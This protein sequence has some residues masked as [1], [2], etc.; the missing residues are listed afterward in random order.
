MHAV[1]PSRDPR[2]AAQRPNAAKMVF[3]DLVD[4]VLV[5]LMVLGPAIAAALGVID[6]IS[7]VLAPDDDQKRAR[8]AASSR[9]AQHRIRLHEQRNQRKKTDHRDHVRAAIP[10]SGSVN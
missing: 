4:M 7:Q 10:R 6:V 9:A 8:A 1:C 3:R 5:A 2:A